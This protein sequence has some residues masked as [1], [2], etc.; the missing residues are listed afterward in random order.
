[1]CLFFRLIAVCTIIISLT[2][3]ASQPTEQKFD[4]HFDKL[5]GQHVDT[6]VKIWGPAEATHMHQDGS[7]TY[8]WHQANVEVWNQN[9]VYP[10][11][12]VSAFNYWPGAV[13]RLGSYTN[14]NFLLFGNYN[15][16]FNVN[17]PM[18]LVHHCTLLVTTDPNGVILDHKTMGDDCVSY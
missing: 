2:A 10:G 18:R 3:C 4:Q 8:K 15:G 12:G 1:M 5:K 14:R 7:M 6:I 16:N 17:R 11:P 13:Y 9:S